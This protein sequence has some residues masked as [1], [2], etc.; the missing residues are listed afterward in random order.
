MAMCARREPSAPAVAPFWM[1]SSTTTP[2]TLPPR[3]LRR[4]GFPM[5]GLGGKWGCLVH[6]GAPVGL[7]GAGR[8]GGE[9]VSLLDPFWAGFGG[10]WRA[11]GA[12]PGFSGAPVES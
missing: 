2:L 9:A 8:G 5:Q 3:A 12:W 4:P 1:A 11:G 7:V 6:G 10:C